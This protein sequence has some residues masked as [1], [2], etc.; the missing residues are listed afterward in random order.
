MSTIDAHVH[1]YP[2]EVNADPAAWAAAHGESHWQLLATR[3]RRDGRPVQAFPA[4]E[5]LIRQMDA[6]EVRQ[7][8]LLGWYWENPASAARQNAFYRECRCRFPTRLLAFATFHPAAGRAAVLEELQRCRDAGLCGLGELS[9]PAQG[10]GRG[11]PVFATALEFA[12]AA[13]WPVNLHVSDPDTPDYPG[14]RA[15]PR[16]EFVALAQSFPSV[17]FILAHWGGRLPLG[18]GPVPANLYFDTAASPL[19][20]GPA[21]WAAMRAALPPGKIIFGSDYPLNLYPRLGAVPQMADFVRA[22]RAAGADAAELGDNL[23]RLLP[24]LQGPVAGG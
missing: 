11:D 9:P 5:E 15:T 18:P 7:A 20:Y 12:A 2:E 16:A 8:V 6:A 24:A 19:T 21:I 23:R 17:N 22:A 13:G 10:Y 3:V 1:L 4:V 14:K